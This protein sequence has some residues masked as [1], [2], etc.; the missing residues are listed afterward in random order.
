VRITS[1]TGFDETGDN[2]PIYWEPTY[3]IVQALRAAH[4]DVDVSGVGLQQLFDWIVALPNFA[5]DPTIVSDELLR[6]ILR[7]WYEESEENNP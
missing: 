4:P 3:E 2:Y 6:D 7:E 5:D 1:T